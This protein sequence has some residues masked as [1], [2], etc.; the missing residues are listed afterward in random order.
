MQQ[1]SLV[2]LS[3]F[4]LAACT[5]A[6]PVD[7][8][9]T[10]TNASPELTEQAATVLILTLDELSKHNSAESCW[11]LV[12]G[13]FYDVT[14]YIDVHPGGSKILQACGKESTQL[15]ESI[16]A[17]VAKGTSQLTNYYLGDLALD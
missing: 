3:V 9:T 12:N 14:A 2:L 17:H 5:Q 15:F 7:N 6:S 11:T 8:A 4:L 10:T 16:P 1:T 13:K